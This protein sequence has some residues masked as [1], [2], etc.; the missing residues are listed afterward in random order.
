MNFIIPAL[1]ANLTLSLISTITSTTNSVYTLSKNV[2]N[3]KVKGPE[4]INLLIEKR[5]LAVNLDLIKTQLQ[6][7]KVDDKTPKTLIKIMK[8]LSNVI[9]NIDDELKKIN[10]RIEYNNKLY[11][12]NM[13]REYKF[14]NCYKRLETN[15][16]ILEMRYQKLLNILNVIKSHKKTN[17]K[18]DE[19]PK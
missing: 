12:A 19:N 8:Y 14:D 7:I 18:E 15:I 11:F 5:D 3:T 6:E 17:K 16:D 9:D 10:Y 2:S 4:Q 1:S 13:F